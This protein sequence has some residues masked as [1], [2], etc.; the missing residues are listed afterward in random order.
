MSPCAFPVLFL[1]ATCCSSSH[2]GSGRPP[3]GLLALGWFEAHTRGGS[4]AGAREMELCSCR[5]KGVRGPDRMSW[6][7][8]LALAGCVV[9][10]PPLLPAA[11]APGDHSRR[12][13][14]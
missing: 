11:R 4:A 5:T 14:P 2:S 3:W 6:G 10:D 1:F 12:S 7:W 13:P 9:W 8:G